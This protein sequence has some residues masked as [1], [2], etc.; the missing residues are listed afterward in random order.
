M[1]LYKIFFRLQV[2]GRENIPLEG[3]FILASNHASFLDP[4]ALA[5]ASPR[6]L[7]FMA[8]EGL[9]RIPLFGRFIASLNAIPVKSKS[10]DLKSLRQAI[11]ELSSGGV[12]N[13]FPEGIRSPNGELGKPLR[14]IGLLAVK[15]D[16]PIVPAFIKGS[17]KA[18]PV[19]SKLIR[20]KK[21]KV[22]FGRPFL[23]K[24]MSTQ[25]SN[26]D[27]YQAIAAR[28][29]DEIKRLKEKSQNEG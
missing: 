14:G 2:I 9:F 24:E 17:N 25:S 19:H 27:L 26:K 11:S 15:A 23:P 13:I 3:G 10:S 12:L 16:V 8:L 29:M 22:Y 18:L 5:V 21:I 20:P 4:P 6:V 7:S 28:T 1:I